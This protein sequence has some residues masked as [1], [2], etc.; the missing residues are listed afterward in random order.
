[1]ARFLVRLFALFWF[2]SCSAVWCKILHS[3]CCLSLVQCTR[4]GTP[5]FQEETAS[6]GRQKGKSL[7]EKKWEASVRAQ[8]CSAGPV[9]YH[10]SVQ[11]LFCFSF[12][13][14]GKLDCSVLRAEGPYGSVWKPCCVGNSNWYVGLPREH[15]LLEPCIT[16]SLGPDSIITG[17]LCL[18]DLLV[19][20]W[21]SVFDGTASALL[22][23]WVLNRM[24]INVI[25]EAGPCCTLLF[26][27]VT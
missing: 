11:G 23:S 13:F 17:R 4:G 24:L 12:S 9:S 2:S 18:C 19:V 27:W 15:W 21:L 10:V 7:Q 16:R 8:S 26:P 1:M 20:L 3:S 25:H 6:E 5:I 14:G 22:I